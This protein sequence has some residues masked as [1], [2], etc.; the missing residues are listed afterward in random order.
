MGTIATGIRAWQ[1]EKGPSYTGPRPSTLAGLG[2]NS[3][4][5]TGNYFADADFTTI[6]ITGVDP[7]TFTIVCTP[8]TQAERPSTPASVTMTGNADGTVIWSP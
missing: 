4:D 2:F 5:C 1:A 7:L 8:T 3:G 6:S